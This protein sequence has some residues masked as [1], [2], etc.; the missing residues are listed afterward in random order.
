[1]M[2]HLCAACAHAKLHLLASRQ[3]GDKNLFPP[4]NTDPDTFV[5]GQEDGAQEG[6]GEADAAP[7]PAPNLGTV[8]VQTLAACSVQAQPV[9]QTCPSRTVL[10]QKHT[11][12]ETICSLMKSEVLKFFYHMPLLLW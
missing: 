1:M 6:G 5:E 4:E 8:L 7:A 2:L 12:S 11:L 3:E 10:S 9:T